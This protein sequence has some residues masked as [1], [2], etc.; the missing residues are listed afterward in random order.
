MY[1]YCMLHPDGTPSPLYYAVQSELARISAFSNVYLA[2]DW[3]KTVPVAKEGE[4]G[5]QALRL[6]GN[7]DF[8]DTAIKK[9]KT[10]EDV[11]VGCFDAEKDEAFMLVNYGNPSDKKNAT[12]EMEFSKGKYAAIYG[13]NNEL[14]IVKL[15]DGKLS[16]MLPTGHGCFV[17]LL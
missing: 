8:T 7:I 17:T 12:V 11:I 15:D 10:S 4:R 5:S 1:E 2:Y 16:V 14:Q 9:V 6:L 3:V 13:I